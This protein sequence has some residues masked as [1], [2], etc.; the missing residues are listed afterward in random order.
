MT[1]PSEEPPAHDGP[2]PGSVWVVLP[3]YNERDNLESIVAAVRAWLPLATV[4]VVD[5]GSPDGTGDIADLLAGGDPHVRVLHRAAKGGLWP[6]YVAGIDTALAEGAEIVVQMDA[7]GSHDPTVLPEL[8]GAV[9]TGYDLAIGSRYVPGGGTPDWPLSRRL[10][11]RGGNLFAQL[12]LGLPYPDTT[13][14]FR[15]WKVDFLRALDFRSI[16]A[17]GYVCMI[18][19]AYRAHRQRAKVR[20]VPITFMNRRAGVSKMSGGIFAEALVQVVKLRLTDWARR[21]RGTRTS[22]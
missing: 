17:T 22:S 16:K 4:L 8:V 7:D 14:G 18:E 5:D 2:E 10:V 15:A 13:G 19:M 21:R 12:I 11:S 1:Q 6:A 20:Q 9:R 3:T